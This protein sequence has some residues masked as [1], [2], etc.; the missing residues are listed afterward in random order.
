MCVC[1]CA[2]AHT[3]LWLLLLFNKTKLQKHCKSS[4]ITK[5]PTVEKCNPNTLGQ[6]KAGTPCSCTF[7]IWVPQT[8]ALSC[9]CSSLQFSR[10][11]HGVFQ[12]V[13]AN[14]H[15][16]AHTHSRPRIHTKHMHTISRAV[17]TSGGVCF[18]GTM[19]IELKLLWPGC[20]FCVHPCD[21]WAQPWQAAPW[22]L[23]RK[24]WQCKRASLW[25]AKHS[26]T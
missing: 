17:R 25:K 11:F 14:T 19:Q 18:W 21:P 1:V 9:P 12:K 23:H 2:R 15:T 16:H 3:L 4:C 6:I 8:G 7:V 22:E 5:N 20:G 24:G 13:N 10:P 26:Y